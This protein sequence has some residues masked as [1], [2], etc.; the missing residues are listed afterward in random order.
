MTQAG[1]SVTGQDLK[2]PPLRED[3]QIVQGAPTDDGMPTW[4]IIDPVRNKYFQI[5]WVPYQ[6]LS[7]WACGSAEQLVKTVT[8]ETTCQVTRTDV[9]ELVKFVYGHNLTLESATGKSSA[10]VSQ[11]LSGR[12][13]WLMWMVHNYLFIRIPLVRPDRFL[14]ATLP[15]V[16][17]LFTK[18]ARRLIV[19]LGIVGVYLAGRQW[20]SFLNTFLYFFTLK[21][22]VLYGLALGVLKILHEL[23]HAYTATRYGCRVPTIGVA[24]IVLFPVL[25]TDTTGAWRLTSRRQRLFIGAAGT[26]VEVALAILAT[27]VWNFLPDGPLRSVAFIVATTSWVMGVMINLNPFL[28]FDGYY[29]LCDWLGVPNL[30]D[31]AFAFGTWKLRQILFGIDQDPPEHFSATLRR[32][33]ILYAWAVW[34]YRFFLFLGIAVLVYYFFFKV[35]GVLLFVVEIVWFILLPIA[36]EVKVWWNMR[37]TITQKSRFWVTSTIVVALVA[38][39]VIPWPTRVS[40]PAVLQ[41]TPHA[42][43]FAPAPGR[44]VEVSLREGQ[45]V[46]QGDLLFTLEAPVI[47]K[48]IALTMKQIEVLEL[49]ARRQAASPEDLAQS[50]VVAAALKT[51]LSELKGLTEEQDDLT[52]RAPISGIVTDLSESLHPGRWVNEEL[53]LAFLVDPEL[54]E[55]QALALESEVARLGVGQGA[56]FIPDDPTRPAI[57]A[58]IRDIRQVDEG[59]FTLLYLA[60]IFGGE[61]PVRRSEN[62]KLQPEASVYRVRLEILG[63]PP[64]WHQAVRGSLLVEGRHWSLAGLVWDR[65]AAVL[66]RESGF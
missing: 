60:S 40:I 38:L 16:D 58:R 8:S 34:V 61:I 41:A 15:F 52:L 51:R 54:K 25:Y 50:Q 24:F 23:G 14:R 59:A 20:E 1:L 43:V 19:L 46:T 64:S 30:Q 56:R 28:R 32:K 47:H 13:N 2:L 42:T 17:P 10:F 11:A 62:G 63:A 48:D 12:K 5:G 6:L 36:R 26:V 49:R 37:S 39:A 45:Y 9:Q 57:E 27:F 65:V 3:I 31:R 55:L 53:P 7:R 29:I 4:T 44:I 22:L 21:G 18:T 66:I 35:L 33:L